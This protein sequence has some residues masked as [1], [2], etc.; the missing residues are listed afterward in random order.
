MTEHQYI[1]LLA[2][3]A[4]VVYGC[5]LLLCVV[6]DYNKAKK[7]KNRLLCGAATITVAFQLLAIAMII[8]TLLVFLC[9][10]P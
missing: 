9:V 4:A 6:S 7:E 10:S 5:A 3:C 1:T 8:G 2:L